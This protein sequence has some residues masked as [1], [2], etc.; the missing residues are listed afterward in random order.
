MLKPHNTEDLY[1]MR[2][3]TRLHKLVSLAVVFSLS[4]F[5]L[6]VPVAQA[7]LVGTAAAISSPATS[8]NSERLRVLSQLHRQD[9]QA[10]L[11][12]RGVDPA[13]VQARVN[14][15]SDSEV[16]TLAAQLDQLPAGAGGLEVVLV[17]F[18]ILILTDIAG[19]THI[20]TFVR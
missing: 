2:I 11:K 12:A 7:T 19:I 3:T 6:Y 16:H 4:S 18:L 10:Q 13:Q 15:L 8:Q 17:V 14:S 1:T 9:V 20:F 5:S